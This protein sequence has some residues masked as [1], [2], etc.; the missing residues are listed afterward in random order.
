MAFIMSCL[1][2]VFC[3]QETQGVCVAT[4]GPSKSFPAFFSPH[5]GF[6]SPY[7][8]RNP[9][10][11]AE[12]IGMSM[13]SCQVSTNLCLYPV[14]MFLFASS[15]SSLS[16]GL[17]SGVLLAV[18]IPEEHSASGQQV[19]EAIQTALEEARYGNSLLYC[20]P[21]SQVFSGFSFVLF[22]ATG[23][24]GRDVTPF[25]LQQVNRLTNGKSLQA[26]ILLKNGSLRCCT[27]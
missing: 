4:Y 3:C 5:S 22:S 26:S 13:F 7:H 6:T 27:A 23:I 9:E 10:E 12:L 24:T 15:A 18:P 19:E 20:N 25:I 1:C 16:L 2:Y 8:I 21:F 14:E 11:A 17:Q